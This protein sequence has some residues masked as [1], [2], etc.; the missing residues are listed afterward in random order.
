MALSFYNIKKW[1][2]MIFGKSL[3]HVKQG[4]GNI[5]SFNGVRGYYNDFTQ[6][7]TKDTNNYN[8]TS[9]IQAPDSKGVPFYFSISIFQYGLGAYDLYLLGIDVQIM[10]KKFLSHLK[11]AVENQRD[12]GSWNTF[13]R[14]Y[15]DAPF[16]SMAQS[17]GASLLI[18]GYKHTGDKEL[19]LRAKKALDFMLLP[20]VNGGT[21]K[22][23]NNDIFFY[24]F[25]CFPYVYNGWIFSLFGLLDYYI[26]TNDDFYKDVID[27]SINTMA[28]EISKMDNGYWSMYRDDDTIA[29]SFYHDLHIHL[30]KV[31]YKYT[32]DHNFEKLIYRFIYYQ[33]R[34]INR[35][36]AFLLK[37]FQKITRK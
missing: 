35:L 21:T 26:E 31:L 34:P 29:S 6:K 27:R 14:D 15:P 32:S 11:W 37:T 2:K 18:R 13:S 3:L 36:R 19:L 8:N 25:T 17:E 22:Y 7:V 10:E 9:V 4:E 28:R 5:Y 30:L 16:S 12:D 23:I 33:K 24:E 20:I 1:T